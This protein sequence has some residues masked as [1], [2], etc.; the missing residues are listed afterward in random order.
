MQPDIHLPTSLL[1]SRIAIATIVPP[2]DPA[3]LSST[4][5]SLTQQPLGN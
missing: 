3:I 1:E 5:T 2:I 4:L